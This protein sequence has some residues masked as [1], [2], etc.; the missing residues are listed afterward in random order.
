MADRL[1]WS[2]RTPLSTIELH[3]HNG[4]AHMTLS[5]FAMREPI[6]VIAIG[7]SREDL[8]ALHFALAGL[9]IADGLQAGDD[10]S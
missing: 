5:L 6:P 4:E 2:A 10:H 3:E 7:V 1:V 9:L 8:S